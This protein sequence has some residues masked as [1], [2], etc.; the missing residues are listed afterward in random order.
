VN[1]KRRGNRISLYRSS[2]VP[3]GPEVSHGHTR[4]TFI[5]S[6]QA[7]ATEISPELAAA[8]TLDECEALKRR[9][10]V[11]AAVAR[12]AAARLARQRDADPAWRLDEA[13]RLITEAAERSQ[14]L[15]VLTTRPQ[16][17][18][19]VVDKVK[20]LGVAASGSQSTPTPD[21]L[22]DALEAIAGA[23]EAVRQ[24]RYGRG[25][26]NGFRNTAVFRHWT[27]ILAAVDASEHSLLRA[28]QDAGFASRRKK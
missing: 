19:A 16:L 13:L 4:Q 15:P 14:A 21:P 22:R 18:R 2:W 12:E 9:V 11:P 23:S 5:G 17:L 26:K 28:L 27:E 20:T 6:I 24:G 25:P 7:D 10:L 1:F 3:K 8:L